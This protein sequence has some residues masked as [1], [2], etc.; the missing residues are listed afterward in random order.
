M[1]CAFVFRDGIAREMPFGEAINL[2]RNGGLVWLQIDGREDAARN[3]IRDQ[4]DIPHIAREAML[5]QE[6]RPRATLIG[7][8]ALVNLRGLGTTPD[9]DPDALVSTRFWADRGRVI[10]VSFR[11]PKALATVVDR[12]HAGEIVDPGDLLSRFAEATSDLLDPDVAELGDTMDDCEVVVDSA[13]ILATRRRVTEVRSQAISYRRFVAPQRQALERL[14]AAELDWLD[15]EDR[16]HLR[17]AADRA[18]RMAE[19]LEAMR[20]RA[21]LIHE[22]LTDRRAEVIDTRALLISIVAL[23]FLPLTFVTGLLGMNVDGI[24]YAHEPWAFWGVVGFCVVIGL[25]VLGWFIKAHWIDR[26]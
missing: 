13:S 12:F 15:E 11:T 26:D 6:T 18:A 14:A 19:E 8:G 9:D 7:N 16:M 2:P 21:A 4:A 10:S 22:E 17:E 24:P 20:E 3:W 23:I 25:A 1:T 5:A